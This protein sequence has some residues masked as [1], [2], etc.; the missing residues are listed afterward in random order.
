MFVHFPLQHVTAPDV[1]LVLNVLCCLFVQN[2]RMEQ[3]LADVYF[4]V[5]M[6]HMVGE[7]M[8]DMRLE[9]ALTMITTVNEVCWRWEYL[10][11]C[12]CVY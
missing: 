11:G 4:L 12:T 6:E 10:G 8:A 5:A 7:T 2:P 9:T 3:P 1:K